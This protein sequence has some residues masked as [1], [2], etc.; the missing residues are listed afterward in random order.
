MEKDVK[1]INL[2]EYPDKPKRFNLLRTLVKSI[3]TNYDESLRNVTWKECPYCGYR[4]NL[5]NNGRQYM[6]H[7]K[8]Y[9]G[10]YLKEHNLYKFRNV[11]TD[12]NLGKYI[13]DF[14]LQEFPEF[15]KEK[16]KQLQ[17]VKSHIKFCNEENRNKT[18]IECPFCGL[19]AKELISHYKRY[20]HINDISN[21]DVKSKDIN[22][23]FGNWLRKHLEFLENDLETQRIE[24]KKWMKANNMIS[25]ISGEKNPNHHSKTS[26]IQRKARSPKSLEFY[27]RKHPELLE[28]ECKELLQQQYNKTR[29]TSLA[30]DSYN[31]T[32]AYWIKLCNGNEELAKEMYKNRQATKRLERFINSYGEDEGIRRFNE[33]ND[34]WSK[35]IAKVFKS[36]SSETERKF[37]D[38]LLNEFPNLNKEIYDTRTYKNSQ[39]T[40][41]I[42]TSKINT[43][44]KPDITILNKF[45]IDFFGDYTHGNPDIF[46]VNFHITF[47]GGKY[48][49]RKEKNEFDNKRKVFL[50]QKGYRVLYIWENDFLNHKEK[51]K[52]QISEFLKDIF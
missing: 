19:R 49:T 27:L 45:I 30:N 4:V 1:I 12:S 51:V 13:N 9:H 46:D 48:L 41:T 21:L 17:I 28:K 50:E 33:M 40:I 43:K 22:S 14:K 15:P 32:L 6:Y 52:Q 37:V 35:S 36:G 31:T 25:D 7:I 34:K 47:G 11:I 38:W 42:H 18:W 2:D 39:R 8:V 44:Y 29:N 3:E 16:R 23:L 26:E 20:H 10:K 5:S 24:F